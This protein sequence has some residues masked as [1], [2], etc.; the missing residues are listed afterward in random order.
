MASIIP[1]FEYDIFISYRQKDNKYDGW[2]TEFVDHLK[3]E[4]EATFKEDVSIYFDENPHDGLLEIHNVD[5]SLEKKLKSL[6]F[7]PIISQTYC[8]TNTFAWQHEFVAFHNM[9][10]TDQYGLD[11]TL[12]SGNVCSRII[13]VKIHD[14][15][16]SDTETIEN[17]MGCR[18]RSIEFIFSTP[19]VNRPLKPGDNP[20][21]NLNK[22]FYRDQINKV[23]NS[24][25][26]LI[27]SLHPDERKRATKSYQTRTEA[28]KY[29]DTNSSATPIPAGIKRRSLKTA[30][31]LAI[32]LI[33][34]LAL[35][36]LIV[37]RSKN[38]SRGL[39]SEDAI[40]TAIA[41]MPVSNFTGSSDL[42]WISEMIQSDLTGHL[43]GISNLIVRPKQTTLQFRNSNEAI[44]QIAKKLSVNN[45]IETSI[46]GNEENLQLEI[47]FVEAF[48]E[49]RYI[50]R[51]TFNKSFNKLPEAY[52]EIIS[53][54]L[55]EVDVT[56]TPKEEQIINAAVGSN[57]DVKKAC[58]RGLYYMNL[59]TK[60]G[61]EKGIQ[62]YK[63]AIALDPADPE[64]YIGLALGYSNSSHAAG[65][66][67]DAAALAKA[68]ALK[69]IEL[70]PQETNPNL[71]DA[72]VVLAT[73]FLYNEWDF[74]KAEYHLKRSIELNP[75]SSAAHYTYGWYLT[76]TNKNDQ[77]VEEM[78]K[79]IAIDP[80]DPICPG[81]L[82][83]LYLWIGN[84]DKA[85]EEADK[86]LLVN[87]EYP[88]G[89]YVKG[90][91]LAKTGKYSEGIEI[92]KDKCNI[93]SGFESGLGI[94][95]AISGDIENSLDIATKM[96]EQ[97]IPWNTAG[98]ANIYAALGDKEKA[99][100]WVQ[101]A[102]K[103][104]HDFAPWLK[105]DSQLKILQDEPAFIEIIK[106]LN[107][108]QE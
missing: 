41:I 31:G 61:F 63:D 3:R 27:Y 64:P 60:E 77:A 36:F 76:L 9:A 23:A 72:H 102:Y 91:S 39:L 56:A 55:K 82:A 1:G 10:K 33:V 15:D 107:L 74:P 101:E 53:K 81:Y 89:F 20:D 50:W 71:A 30:G 8:D 52:S 83:W 11:I 28:G 70:D 2:V 25:K 94:A 19:G 4:I 79:A 58:A 35:I 6:V 13:P 78:K 42:E 97:N 37:K 92:L 45:L 99:L 62:Y 46:K 18:L 26:E 68:Y 12:P 65:T 105:F 51:S 29:T 80:L 59:L 88:M 100:F 7:I 67:E 103:V 43:Q 66:S 49:E 34:I 90:L 21:K 104:R 17:E 5:K 85:L 24:V 87:P 54:I 96:E 48:P 98:L 108:P 57:P 16:A 84:Y 93:G 106:K 47:S 75:S 86:T 14:I 38:D 44:Q 22:T 69:A 95:Y 32:G 73:R 40:K